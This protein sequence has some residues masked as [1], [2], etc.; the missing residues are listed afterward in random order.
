[1]LRRRIN[2]KMTAI[3]F[4]DVI[5]YDPVT[6]WTLPHWCTYIGYS[7]CFLISLFSAIVVI[8]YGQQFG[9][10]RSVKWLRCLVFG[11]LEDVFL[12]FPFL[13]SVLLCNKMCKIVKKTV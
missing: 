9:R 1:M 3:F 12:T 10:D 4:I 2:Y 6:R 7:C 5:E 11:F 8:T 13:V